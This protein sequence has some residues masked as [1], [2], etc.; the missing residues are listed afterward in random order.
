MPSA[1]RR[2][3][4]SSGRA[5]QLVAKSAAAS[6]CTLVFFSGL[7]FPSPGGVS[8]QGVLDL[9]VGRPKPLPFPV[10]P[11]DVG[12][13]VPHRRHLVLGLTLSVQIQL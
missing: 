10:P 7:T 12:H 13:Q 1:C 6:C 11:V 3:C 9:L 5:D 2:V 8:G 4:V